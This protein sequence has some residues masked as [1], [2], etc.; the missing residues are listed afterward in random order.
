ML[1]YKHLRR[2]VNKLIMHEFL[3]DGFHLAAAFV[4]GRVLDFM[5]DFIIRKIFEY[6]R[7][8]ALF[9]SLMRRDCYFLG[10]L[11]ASFCLSLVEQA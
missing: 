2:Y 6:L 1:A 3:T 4:A 10:F 5:D 8:A 9:L 7:A 11:T